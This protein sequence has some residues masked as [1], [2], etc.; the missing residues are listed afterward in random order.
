MAS[1]G[2]ST[3]PW[4]LSTRITSP[5]RRAATRCDGAVVVGAAGEAEQAARLPQLAVGVAVAVE[6]DEGELDLE[7]DVDVDGQAARR[8]GVK[9]RVWCPIG[10]PLRSTANSWAESSARAAR[11]GA[12][13]GMSRAHR[14]RACGDRAWHPLRRHRLRA[15]YAALAAADR[16]FG[17]QRGDRRQL[18]QAGQDRPPAAAGRSGRRPARSCRRRRRWRRA[19]HRPGRRRRPAR[20]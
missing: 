6:G 8:R 12:R 9:R 16:P 10:E 1:P 13:S 19:G 17:S 2:A 20:R 11:A 14:R 4:S 5:A 7:L 15:G 3:R 18:G